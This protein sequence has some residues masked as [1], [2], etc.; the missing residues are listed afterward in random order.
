[1]Y[2]SFPP[3]RTGGQAGSL[4]LFRT[5]GIHPGPSAKPIVL[6][7]KK[8]NAHKSKKILGQ[9]RGVAPLGRF[10]KSRRRQRRLPGIPLAAT[11]GPGRP[12]THKN[13]NIKED[14]RK[15]YDKV[16]K[17]QILISLKV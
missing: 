7:Q 17:G 6:C 8:K 10:P 9:Y 1:M 3:S 12:Q 4:G 5:L 2:H 14:D 16:P 15:K 13:K 11:Q